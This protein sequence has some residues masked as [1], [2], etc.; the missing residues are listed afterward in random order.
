MD[1]KITT[2]QARLRHC[3]REL[4]RK[5]GSKGQS[6]IVIKDANVTVI[7]SD[8]KKAIQFYVQTL[9]LE[10]KANYGDQYAQVHAPGVMIGLHPASASGPKPGKSESL[11]IGFGVDNLNSAMSE[12]KGEGVNFSRMVEDRP[13]KLAFFA[14]PDGIPSI[15]QR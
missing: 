6:M 7:V 9:G 2:D 8:M 4:N 3:E 15:S 14:D 5:E 10:L 1:L 12:L 11:S 13:T